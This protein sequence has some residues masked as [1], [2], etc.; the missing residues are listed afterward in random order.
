MLSLVNKI[1]VVVEMECG[2]YFEVIDIR[3][4]LSSLVNFHNR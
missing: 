3:D 1:D 2:G 4:R